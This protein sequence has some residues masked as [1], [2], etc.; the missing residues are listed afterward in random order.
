MIAKLSCHRQRR[1]RVIAIAFI[2]TDG[3]AAHVES[4]ASRKF[5]WRWCDG[6]RLGEQAKFA[7]RFVG[8]KRR[9]RQGVAIGH[10]QRGALV[11][12]LKE[13]AVRVGGVLLDEVFYLLAKLALVRCI[14]RS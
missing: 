11:D 3:A 5:S 14:E 7:V 4:Q 9:R 13:I 1:L 10:A 8:K 6:E 12:L 2:G